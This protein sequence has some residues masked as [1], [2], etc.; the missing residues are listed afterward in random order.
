MADLPVPGGP[1]RC[2]EPVVCAA[3]VPGRGAM[4]CMARAPNTHTMREPPLWHGLPTV[5]LPLT[6]G[7]H[8]RA[9]ALGDLRSGP[10]A[11]SGDRATTAFPAGGDGLHCARAKHTHT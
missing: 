5:P 7:L 3:G 11:R 10:V 1:D 2:C 8:S 6:E 9:R 4:D